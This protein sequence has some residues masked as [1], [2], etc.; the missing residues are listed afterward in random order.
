MEQQSPDKRMRIQP[1]ATRADHVAA[2]VLIYG[3][4]LVTGGSYMLLVAGLCP[5]RGAH[6]ALLLGGIAT[7]AG[8]VAL[9]LGLYARWVDYYLAAP[10]GARFPW[11]RHWLRLQGIACAVAP[12]FY[13]LLVLIRLFFKHIA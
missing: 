12:L 9:A 13:V 4:T 1:P 11:L 8:N 10:W 7:I 5:V 3:G 2:T 6:M